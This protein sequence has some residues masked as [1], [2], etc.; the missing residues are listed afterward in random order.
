MNPLAV[1]S[2]MLFA[3]TP[4][5][6]IETVARS[7]ATGIEWRVDDRGPG[8]GSDVFT[9]NRCTL[10][11]EDIT[12][13]V[14]RCRRAGLEVVGLDTYVDT[15]DV[16]TARR[17]AAAAA[18]AGVGWF[19]FR[20]PWRDG[21]AWSE[22]AQAARR[23]VDELERITSRHGVRAL[24]E[25]HQRSICPSASLTARILDGA[26]PALIGAIYDVGNLLVEGYED[27][28][29]AIE[30][31]G[32]HLAHVHVKNARYV[33]SGPGTPWVLQWSPMDDGLLDIVA[34]RRALHRGG[35]RG[36]LSLEDF[37]ADLAPVEA[38]R[39]GLEVLDR[40]EPALVTA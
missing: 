24:L 8:A 28:D 15:G 31:L 6:A 25:L 38:L 32:A 16:A 39:R 37:T 22:H 27:H 9:D 13:T 12:R 18:E 19:R 23:F 5:E 10:R 34:L 4:E 20:A 3:H 14:E 33:P 1:C 29:T 17:A 21:T 11:F 7:G 35:Y 26:D 36:W 30:L 40:A 2:I